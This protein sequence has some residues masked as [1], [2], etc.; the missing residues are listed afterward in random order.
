MRNHS[1]TW[2]EIPDWRSAEIRFGDLI[3]RSGPAIEQFI[4]SGNLG[5]FGRDTGIDPEGVGALGLA[6]GS[7]Y[8]VRLARDRLLGI[9][10]V[11]RTIKAGWNDGGY[12]VTTL[13]AAL[14]IFEIS[15]ANAVPL[16]LRGTPLDPAAA[17]PCAVVAFAGINVSLYRFDRSELFRVHVDRGLAT[18]LWTWFE[19]AASAMA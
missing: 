2:S 11:P 15:G 4:V 5:A 17:G 3:V 16:I 19:E 8:T 6:K 9:G 18:Y 12:A 13:S 14:Q 10:P 1:L 7:D